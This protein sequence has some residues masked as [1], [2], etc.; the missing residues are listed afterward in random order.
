MTATTTAQPAALPERVASLLAERE[1]LQRA[2]GAAVLDGRTVDGR[3][4]A[5]IDGEL[6][7]LQDADAEE[8]RRQHKAAETHKVAHHQAVRKRIAER[9]QERLAALAKAEAAARMMV[10]ALD[11]VRSHAIATRAEIAELGV[12]PPAVFDARELETRLSRYLANSLS[13]VARGPDFGVLEWNS[14]PFPDGPW[15][16]LER[17]AT[18]AAL[19]ELTKES[20]A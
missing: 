5:A 20:P 17:A 13:I 9:E 3:R 7:A 16:E 15:A 2:R 10:K 19:S 12:P 6:A 18:A 1:K 14:I 11:V 8:R 4:L